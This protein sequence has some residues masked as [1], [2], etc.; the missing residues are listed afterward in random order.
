MLSA[1]ILLT[2]F[3]VSHA[4]VST[5]VKADSTTIA[6]PS[7]EAEYRNAEIAAHESPLSTVASSEAR[8]TAV[9]CGRIDKAVQ[10]TLE[11]LKRKVQRARAGDSS[12][13][14]VSSHG[15]LAMALHL[16]AFATQ[17]TRNL[18]RVVQMQDDSADVLVKSLTLTCGG[19]SNASRALA[20]AVAQARFTFSMPREVAAAFVASCAVS[21]RAAEHLLEDGAS[22]GMRHVADYTVMHLLAQFGDA[23]LVQAVAAALPPGELSAQ[24]RHVGSPAQVTPYAIAVARGHRE[25][26]AA[27]ARLAED[28]GAGDGTIDSGASE[29]SPSW[30]EGTLAACVDHGP[31]PCKEDGCPSP[32]LGCADL[33]SLNVCPRSFTDVWQSPPP[34]TDGMRV[35]DLCPRA[36]GRCAVTDPETEAEN[37]EADNGGWGHST[38]QLSGM[39]PVEEL[40][41]RDNEHDERCDVAIEGGTHLDAATFVQ[42]YVVPERPVLIRRGSASSSSIADLRQALSRRALLASYGELQ[43]NVG[44]APYYEAGSRRSMSLREYAE[45]MMMMAPDGDDASS[46]AAATHE[47]NRTAVD[48]VFLGLYADG[49]P[50]HAR[51]Q[52]QL[53]GA[54]PHFAVESLRSKGLF[55]RASTQFSL[56]PA[57]SGSPPHYHMAALNT[58][59]YGK[60]RWTLVPPRSAVYAAKPVREWLAGG[61]A[62][63]LRAEGRP[64]LECVQR[65]GDVLWVPDDWGHAVL[66]V[67]PSVGFASEF[68]TARGCSMRMEVPRAT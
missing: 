31:W 43:V 16:E 11:T 21:Q 30:S 61:G 66:N 37:D 44:P 41:T 27:L 63:A 53:D 6:T 59:V 10:W 38:A 32:M 14:A 23:A 18:L 20:A 3:R 33:A 17:I 4:V 60:K 68:A 7:V 57:G 52:A 40:S 65:A 24:L 55:Y 45:E 8:E 46:R 22:G 49:D 9:S 54:L 48:Y 64:V 28:G 29:D 50:L 47:A 2:S 56:G 58:L 42:R 13:A 1:L 39:L 51:L 15:L 26:A 12:L 35:S 19:S 34:R 25:C 36:C 62:A 67:W 5:T